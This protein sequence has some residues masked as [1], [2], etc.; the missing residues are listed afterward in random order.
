M[1][2][3]EGTPERSLMG[4]IWRYFLP[5]SQQTNPRHNAE[6]EVAKPRSFVSRIKNLFSRSRTKKAHLLRR[7][8]AVVT[9]SPPPTYLTAPSSQDHTSA[10]PSTP[11]PLV[12]SMGNSLDY[13]G[14][15]SLPEDQLAPFPPGSPIDSD[16]H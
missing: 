8:D 7:A 3:S 16:T 12:D 6:A 14:A 4:K 1:D 13:H 11:I 15:R 10:R 2:H 5:H 9:A